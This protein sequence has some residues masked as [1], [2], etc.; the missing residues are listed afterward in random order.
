V[1]HDLNSAFQSWLDDVHARHADVIEH[2]LGNRFDVYPSLQ[3]CLASRPVDVPCLN[4]RARRLAVAATND[5]LKHAA[6]GYDRLLDDSPHAQHA[7]AQLI[8]YLPDTTDAVKHRVDEFVQQG[9]ARSGLGLGQA[10]TVASLILT[11]AHPARFVDFPSHATWTRFAQELGYGIVNT[12]VS[13]GEKLVWASI[14]AHDLA[15][16][17]TFKRHWKR[18]SDRAMWV[19]S[20]LNWTYKRLAQETPREE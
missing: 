5:L 7:I 4:E 15:E 11:L 12:N 3:E 9:K 16:T 6:S 19:I 1:S 2:E 14:F 20:A 8:D 18:E 17:D 13:H 10:L